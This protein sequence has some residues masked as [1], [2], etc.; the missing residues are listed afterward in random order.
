MEAIINFFQDKE[1]ELV[2]SFETPERQGTYKEYESLKL[3]PASNAVLSSFNSGIYEHQWI[4][5]NEFKNGANVCVSTSTSSGKTLIFNIC[6]IEIISKNPEAKILA[7]YPLKALG[8]EQEGRWRDVVSKSGLPYQIGRIDGAVP[9]SEREKIIKKSSIIIMTPDVIHAWLLSKVSNSSITSFLKNVSLLVIDE[10]HTYSGVFGSNSAFLYRRLQ[11]LISI[12]GGDYQIIAA[13]ATIKDPSEHLEK[14]T[15]VKFSVIGDEHET[16]PK[17]KTNII[18]VNTPKTNDLLTSLSNLMRFL[19]N[20]TKYQF[21]TFVDS[22]KQTEYIATISSRKSEKD[23]ELETEAIDSDFIED[24]P[25]CPYRSGYEEADRNII[26]SKLSKGE[27]RGVISTSALEMGIDIPHLNLGILV[28]VPSSAT[29]FYQRIGRIGRHQNGV[30]II[31]NNGS[32]QTESI[33][34]EPERLLE[35]PLSESALYLENPR[36]QYIHTLCLAR[37][38]GEDETLKTILGLDGEEFIPNANFPKPFI[39]LC[40]SER[41]GEISTEFQTMKAQAGED[42]NHVYPL[43]DIDVQYKAE[44]RQGPHLRHLGSLGFSQV[45]REAYPGA[46]YY[47]QT[48]TFRVFRLNSYKHLIEVRP[49]K[50]YT[51]KPTMLPTLIFPNLS[52]GNVIQS[53]KFGDL[54]IVECNLQIRESIAG[55]I[56]TRGRNELDV[57]YP[58]DKSLGLYFDIP[59]FTRN[60]FTSGVIINHP[61][62]DRGIK[63][64]LLAEI[65]YEAFF[66]VIPFERQDIN[67]GSD[68][69]RAERKGFNKG[70]KFLSIFDQTYGSLRLTSRFLEHDVIEKVFSYAIDI[71]E[72]DPRYSH[73]QEEINIL[74]NIKAELNKPEENLFIETEDSLSEDERHTKIILPKSVGLDMRDGRNEE[75]FIEDIFYSPKYGLSYKG[76]HLSETSKRMTTETWKASIPVIIVPVTALHEIPGESKMGLYDYETGDIIGSV[77][78]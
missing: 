63:C 65:I 3:S 78:A 56:E 74:K 54:T 8:T 33:F 68:K 13:S 40:N 75:F 2:R 10:A 46:V 70:S 14:L 43:R 11:H 49:E 73:Y 53:K 51:T 48:Q 23:S 66:M 45:M 28:G 4:A 52:E 30:I 27:L 34:R 39:E 20:D 60:Y 22:R 6:G 61:L 57:S 18:L 15:G 7:I 41:I 12:A 9:Q 36:I 35:I 69:H 38:G 71:A 67:Y 55:F 29:S 62:L 17:K 59:R 1:W 26:Q 77:I 42:P 58:L 24:L 32:I 76:R 37:Q 72:N 25:I 44:C 50:K 19:V 47:Y 64:P 5:I 16:S 31:V 21:I